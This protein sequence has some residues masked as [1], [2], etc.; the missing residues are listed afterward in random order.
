MMGLVA[1]ILRAQRIVCAF[2]M[3]VVRLPVFYPCP[4]VCTVDG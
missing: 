4:F 2:C 3:P 1:R